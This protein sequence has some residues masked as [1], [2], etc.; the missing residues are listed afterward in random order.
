MAHNK[1]LGTV[2]RNMLEKI[3]RFLFFLN[4]ETVVKEIVPERALEQ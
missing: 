1:G 2:S 3:S 4:L